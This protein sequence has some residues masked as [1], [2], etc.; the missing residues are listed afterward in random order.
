MQRK[1]DCQSLDLH[2][3]FEAIEVIAIK[4]FR[5][6]LPKDNQEDPQ[7]QATLGECLS[8]FLAEAAPF[9]DELL[10]NKQW[11]IINLF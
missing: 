11:E 4:L 10:E 3:F 1:Y 7:E 5:P 9:F 6:P 8:Q 2:S